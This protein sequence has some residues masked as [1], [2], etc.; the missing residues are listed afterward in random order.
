MFFLNLIN[1][2]LLSN[3]K[4]QILSQNCYSQQ[5]PISANDES[6]SRRPARQKTYH[7]K[8]DFQRLAA[9]VIDRF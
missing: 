9:S 2:F 3:P 6:V 5:L 7:E 4:S 1:I 8:I